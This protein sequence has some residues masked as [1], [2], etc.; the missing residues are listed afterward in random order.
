LKLI[1][2]RINTQYRLDII[3][4]EVC[5]TIVEGGPCGRSPYADAGNQPLA[6]RANSASEKIV[7]GVEARAYEFP[8]QVC[9]SIKCNDSQLNNFSSDH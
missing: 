4:R 2:D 7:G 5:Y 9:K 1:Y 8:W 6:L 3:Q